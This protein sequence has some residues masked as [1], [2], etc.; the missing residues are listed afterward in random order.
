MKEE[1]YILL[2]DDALDYSTNKDSLGPS[3]IAFISDRFKS[4]KIYL[5][6]YS[7]NLSFEA[8][9]E[10][11]EFLFCLW[12]FPQKGNKQAVEYFKREVNKCSGKFQK[13]LSME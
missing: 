7:C 6:G 4:C 5:G 8:K 12:E 9:P 3:G 1:N 2:T 10:V 13:I 11:K